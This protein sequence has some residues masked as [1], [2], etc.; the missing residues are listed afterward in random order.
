MHDL[1][2]PNSVK[3]DIKKLDKPTIKRVIELLEVLSENPLQGI[4]LIG[5]LSHL[6]KFEFYTQGVVI[7]LFI[8]SFK[9]EYR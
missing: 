7:A 6:L 2:I 1:V 4:Q 5:D 9:N 8:K 3:K